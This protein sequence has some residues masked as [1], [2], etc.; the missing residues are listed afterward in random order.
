MAVSKP[1]TLRRPDVQRQ[2]IPV[3]EA[4]LPLVDR[5]D[6]KR[7]YI[8]YGGRDSA[9][10]WTFAAALL[11]LCQ[12]D[13]LR[14]LCA[15]EIQ[16][17]IADSVHR[18]LSDLITRFGW[19]DLFDVQESRIVCKASG[20]EF[21]FV[22]L[23]DQDAHKIKSYEGVDIVWVEEAH[24]VT[25]RSWNILIPTI[26][27]DRSEIWVTFNPELDTD[28]TYLRFV[29]RPPA[30]GWV[31]KVSWRDNPWFSQVLNEDRERLQ[32]DDPDEYD[33]IWEGNPRSVIPGAIYAK[34]VTAMIQARRVRPVPYDPQLLV[35]TIWDLGWNDETAI[36]FVQRL[37]SEVRVI[38]YEEESFLRFDQWAKRIR[39]RD[40]V[41]GS[42]W[43]P[44]DGKNALQAAGGKSAR[45]IL[46]PLLSMKPKIMPRVHDVEIRVRASRML[47]PRVY[48]D[49]DHCDELMTALKRYRRGVPEST[50]EP[51]KP[52][53]D[54][55][56]HGADAFGGL[57][58]IVDKLTNERER[59]MQQATSFVPSD[60]GMGYIFAVCA[61]AVA[62]LGS[63]VFI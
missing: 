37:L 25:K 20:A 5:E 34:E 1:A 57:A 12:Y 19:E 40:Y 48:V 47:F 7:Y 62:L 4:Y 22:G 61:V 58:L 56:S 35:H 63:T 10:S 46:K 53:H 38:D 44:H 33:N 13:P 14:I 29:L 41:Y 51:G 32:R 31:K 17:T 18:L 30:N 6:R 23:R 45:Q 36:L 50:G 59:A 60:P 16:R 39:D 9:K 28:D 11:L 15:R 3:P 52:V 2:E 24:T 26:R 49:E 54:Q 21:I 42:H 8:A 27:A 43:L 55:Y